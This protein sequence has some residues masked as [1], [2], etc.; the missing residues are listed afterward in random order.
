MKFYDKEKM[1]KVARDRGY[2]S[3]R[4][5]GDA[6]KD[7][8]GVSS[9]SVQNRISSGNLT[10]EECEVIGSY[11]GMTMKEYYDIFMNGLFIEDSEGHYVC[12]VDDPFR[13]LHPISTKP[14]PKTRREKVSEILAEIDDIE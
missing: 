1:M 10:K 6:L 12:Y 11:F 9:K 2:T 4:S 7:S 14:R 3:L 5:I 8:F 13:H